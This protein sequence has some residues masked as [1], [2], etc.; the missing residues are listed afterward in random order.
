MRGFFGILAGLAVMVAIAVVI[1]F[2]GGLIIPSTPVMAN[3]SDPEGVKQAYASLSPEA[4]LLGVMAWSLGGFVG[5]L[6][7]KYIIGRPW[8]V[9]TLTGLTEAYMLITVLMLPMPGWMQVVALVLPLVAGFL[10]NRLV[11]NREHRAD[12]PERTGLDAEA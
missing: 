11:A 1:A 4:Q 8:A 10:A 12:L 3:M 9:W 7:A 5:A 2:V 6:I